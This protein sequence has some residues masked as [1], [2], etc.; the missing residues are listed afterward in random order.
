[1]IVLRR[2]DLPGKQQIAVGRA[3]IAPAASR[4][5][6][7][8]ALSGRTAKSKLA[9]GIQLGGYRARGM[10]RKRSRCS[11]TYVTLPAWPQAQPLQN[12]KLPAGTVPRRGWFDVEGDGYRRDGWTSGGRAGCDPGDRP[13]GD[14]PSGSGEL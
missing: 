10:Q 14:C 8:P 7:V 12:R 1:V 6:T 3:G 2:A 11:P 13:G 5:R 9:R 4:V